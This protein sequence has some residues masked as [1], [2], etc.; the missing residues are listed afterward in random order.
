M[1][2]YSIDIIID[3]TIAGRFHE[4]GFSCFVAAEL[5]CLIV[6]ETRTILRYQEIEKPL[7]VRDL[8]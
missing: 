1:G 8:Y 4:S 6:N 2:G 5:T 7:R 3:I